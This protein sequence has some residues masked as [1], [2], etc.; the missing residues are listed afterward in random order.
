MTPSQTE[1]LFPPGVIPKLESAR[2]PIW[3][4]LILSLAD[5]A[6]DTDQHVAFVLMLA[7]LANCAT[8]NSNSYRAA[9]GCANCSIQVLK[10]FRGTDDDLLQMYQDTLH[11]VQNQ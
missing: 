2:G 9:Q 8:C 11:E 4:E 1:L 7:R 5:Q 10:R 3:K 6:D